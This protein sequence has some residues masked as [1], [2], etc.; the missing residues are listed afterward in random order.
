MTSALI[1]ATGFVGSSLLRQTAFDRLFHSRNIGELPTGQ[2]DLVVCAGAPGQKWIANKDPAADRAR[3]ASLRDAIGKLR[4][5][6]FVLISTVD[7]FTKAAGVDEDSVPDRQNL[8]A[9]GAHRLD[10]EELVRN[11]FADAVIVRLPGLVGPG[12]RKNAIFDLHHNNNVGAIDSRGRFQF[13]PMI[14]LWS[15]L[16]IAME[17]NLKLVHLTAAP[18]SVADIAKEAFGMDFGNV[19]TAPAAVYDFKT[20]HGEVFGG[21]TNYQY[22]RRESMMSIRAYRQSEYR[23]AG[24]KT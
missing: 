7:V 24:D 22:S 19:L 13:Y 20:R 23:P 14:Q 4:C 11:R 5:D 6:R 18:I 12:L 3:L 15:D 16:S 8:T 1:G 10:L 17:R 9:Y 21:I 2:Y